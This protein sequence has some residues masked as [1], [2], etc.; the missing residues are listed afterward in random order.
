ML[1]GIDLGTTHSLVAVYGDDGPVL[2]PNALGEFLTPSVVAV[3]ESQ[4]VLV[5][6]AA[7]ERLVSQPDV[8]VAT[9]KRW[10]GTGR[11]TVLGKKQYR[12]EQLSA[13]VLRSLMDDVGA[14]SG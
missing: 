4:T 7:K 13:L 3:D 11:L 2:V 1:V 10:M 8:S 9:F 14:D 5:G 12:P 6:Q